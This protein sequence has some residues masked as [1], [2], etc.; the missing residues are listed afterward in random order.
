MRALSNM[1]ISYRIFLLAS[2]AFLGL[3]VNAGIFMVQRSLDAD[4]RQK[5]ERF[6]ELSREM[7]GFRTDLLENRRREKDF[8]LRKDEQSQQAFDKAADQANQ[9]LSRL[10]NGVDPDMRDAVASIAV[11]YKTYVDATHGL[12]EKNRDLGLTPD[13]GLEGAMRKAVHNIEAVVKSVEARDLLISVLTLRRHEK[14]FI[15]RRDPKYIGQHA[16][17]AEKLLSIAQEQLAAEQMATVKASLDAYAQAFAR[18]A[19]VVVEEEALRQAASG[20]FSELDPLVVD[21]TKRLDE[22]RLATRAEGDAAAARNMNMVILAG[23]LTA[24]LLALAVFVIGRSISRPIIGITAAMRRLSGGDAD[25]EVQGVER[26]DEIGDMASALEVFRQAALTNIRLEREAAEARSRAEADRI[27]M[28]QEAEAAAQQRLIEATSALAEGLSRLAAGDLAFELPLPFSPDFEQLRHDLN[29]AVRQLGNVMRDISESASIIDGG[30]AEVSSS[31]GDLAQRTERQAAALEQTAAALDEITVNVANAS[32]RAEE[33]RNVA[34]QATSSA[35]RSAQVVSSAVDAMQ[36]IED[37]SSQIS[38]IIGVIDEIAFQTNLLALNAGVEA[39]RA[40]EAGKGFA[41]V[42]QEVRELAQRS[43]NAAREI[44]GLI[45]NSGEQVQGGVKLVRDTGDALRGIGDLVAS[46][47]RHMD[48]IAT[49]SREQSTGLAE[50][51]AAVNQMDQVT[52]R[53]AAMVEEA[54]AASATL[55]NEANRL[56]L[57]ISA[58]RLEGDKQSG[59]RATARPSGS[60]PAT[61]RAA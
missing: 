33:A 52:Q 18:Y 14:D 38:S 27:R 23:S 4:Y 34:Q 2:I 60:V 29:Q 22:A 9:A 59:A 42:A 12:F 49:A 41:V 48:A 32:K 56:R 25:F 58:F 1:K 39:A 61:S 5:T 13:Q 30:S 19:A 10:A 47:N 35:V 54:S 43:A 31:A 51:N 6:A 50:V 37:S 7:A 26:R 20:T 57:L 28:Q 40:G 16:T 36:R 11:G 8:L 46:I 55:A 53:N 44:K 21:A 24:V 17:E 3:A 45:R 15:L